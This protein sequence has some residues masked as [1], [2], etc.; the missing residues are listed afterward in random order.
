MMMYQRND[1]S[2]KF[3]KYIKTEF[4]NTSG[5]AML[6]NTIFKSY[7]Q[8]ISRHKTAIEVLALGKELEGNNSAH[9][10]LFKTTGGVLESHPQLAEEI[11]GPASMLI[12]MKTKDEMLS[13]ARNLSG[14]LTATI[15]GTE[16]DLVAHQDLLDILS[17][18]VGR[19]VINGFPTGVEVCSAMVHG[20]PYPATTDGRST[21]VGTAS[22]FRFTRPVC[23]Q[24]MPQSLLPPELKDGN[25][26]GILRLVN[27][28]RT[29]EII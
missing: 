12:E 4:E 29:K 9:P 19:I 28:A 16:E 6:T 17:Q 14:H 11:F 18:K 13:A 1:T 2:D 5:G 7:T 26:L 15:H 21:S 27:G 24:N 22:I 8:G 3:I 25:P 23:F 10:V 20:G